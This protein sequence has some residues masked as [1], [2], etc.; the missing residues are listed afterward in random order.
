MQ[1]SKKETAMKPRVSLD[2]IYI[3]SEDIVAREIEGEIIIVPLVSGIGDMDDALY[4]LN[5]TGKYIWQKL[6]RK[7]S[8]KDIAR[9]LTSEFDA[10]AKQVEKDVI[11]LIKELFKRRMVV[12]VSKK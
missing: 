1:N 12:E 5:K 11:G 7:K 9:E 6:D 10:T 4:T 8:L 3:P 2:R